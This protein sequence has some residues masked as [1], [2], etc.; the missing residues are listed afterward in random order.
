MQ[1]SPKFLLYII[2]EWFDAFIWEM[3]KTH[4]NLMLKLYHQGIDY[5]SSNVEYHIDFDNYSNK[6]YATAIY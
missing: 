6:L 1:M 2:H 5:R 4:F 3:N